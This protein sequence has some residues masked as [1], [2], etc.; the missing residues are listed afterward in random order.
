MPKKPT[1]LRP[2]WIAPAGEPWSGARNADER[3]IYNTVYNTS[4]WRTIR[5]L[6]RQRDPVCRMC[7]TEPTHTVDHV[8]PIRDGGDAWDM[9]N[10]Q[11]LCKACNAAKTGSQR[12]A[13]QGR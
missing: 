8:K 6:V 7:N 4:R 11:G 1:T 13:R 2:N 10:M 5:N 12:K 3:I 9:D